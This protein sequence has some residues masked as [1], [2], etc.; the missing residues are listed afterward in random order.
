MNYKETL[1]NVLNIDN[2]IDSN[3]AKSLKLKFHDEKLVAKQFTKE[4]FEEYAT[5][6]CE[7]LSILYNCT[8]KY[9]VESAVTECRDMINKLLELNHAICAYIHEQFR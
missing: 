4:N 9:T 8:Q 6:I 7:M 2:E 1:E 5:Q 3:I